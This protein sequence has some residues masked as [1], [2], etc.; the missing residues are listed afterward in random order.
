VTIHRANADFWKD[1]RTLSADIRSRAD[2]QFELL[3]DNPQHPSLQFKKI[4]DRSGQEIW[5]VRVTLK[6]R[7]LAVRL[8]DEYVWFWIGDHNVY[9]A[10]IS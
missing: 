1:Y 2:K 9:E 4:G 3:K 5:S 8:A 10:L 7:A 6:Y